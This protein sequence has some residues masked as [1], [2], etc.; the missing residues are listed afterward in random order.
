MAATSGLEL[1]KISRCAWRTADGQF[2]VIKVKE[3]GAV[4]VY[5][6]W[7]GPKLTAGSEVAR[8]ETLGQ[9][10]EQLSAHAVR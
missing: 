4:G 3:W 8:G 10:R 2:Q 7:R 1:M 6:A 9:I 5:V